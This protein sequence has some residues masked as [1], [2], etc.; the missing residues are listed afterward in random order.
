MKMSARFSGQTLP[1]L[2]PPDQC[3]SARSRKHVAELKEKTLR[4]ILGEKD[5]EEVRNVLAVYG[6]T[7]GE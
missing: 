5:F 3:I 6:M 7:P 4:V 1:H 2:S